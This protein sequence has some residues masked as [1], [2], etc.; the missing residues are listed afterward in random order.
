MREL[1]EIEKIIYIGSSHRPPTRD[2][3]EFT[4]LEKKSDLDVFLVKEIIPV[5]MSPYT[6]RVDFAILCE[7]TNPAELPKSTRKPIVKPKN[8]N[9]SKN[10]NDRPKVSAS[11][12]QRRINYSAPHMTLREARSN[13]FPTEEMIRNFSSSNVRKSKQIDYQKRDSLYPV[14]LRGNLYQ[15]L[16][17]DRPYYAAEEQRYSHSDDFR[18][19]G[20]E[21]GYSRGSKAVN[22][23]PI[24][25]RRGG[26]SNEARQLE[27]YTNFRRD[28]ED[29]L[30][31]TSRFQPK[32]ITSR[33]LAYA[34]AL[35]EEGIRLASEVIDDDDYPTPS[36]LRYPNQQRQR[37]ARSSRYP[38][39]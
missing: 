5:D 27:R 34:N 4:N 30:D 31:E 38:R 25:V 19:L 13:F 24:H 29:V 26:D 21:S 36:Y 7:R 11:N 2:L 17:G 28:L 9:T 8:K 22:P 37:N 1:K 6:M 18:F 12:K 14:P 35:L 32:R 16:D 33:K 15:G 39:Y 10:K 23:G 20:T 3:L